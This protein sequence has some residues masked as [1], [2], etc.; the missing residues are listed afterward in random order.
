[1]GARAYVAVDDVTFRP[2]EVA[3]E[4]GSE[5]GEGSTAYIRDAMPR[6]YSVDIDPA[7]PAGVIRMD[8]AKFLTALDRPIKF[9]YLDSFDWIP[10]GLEDEPWIHEQV[11]DYAARG[12][13]MSNV[14]C[15]AAHLEQ[16]RMVAAKAA[17]GCVIVID[18]TFSTAGGFSG[19]GGTAVPWLLAHGYELLNVPSVDVEDGYALLRRVR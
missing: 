5:R 18:D 8:G 19:K 13:T 1:M 14:N 4:I 3:V 15:Q 6:F 2:G 7:E 17:P 16:A 10:A 9:A 11:R 12:V